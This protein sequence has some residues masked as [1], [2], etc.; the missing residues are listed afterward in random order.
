MI[1]VSTD[2]Y[3]HLEVQFTMYRKVKKKREEEEA[4]DDY[5]MSEQFQNLIALVED[6]LR[7]Q[8]HITREVKRYILIGKVILT[9]FGHTC[10]FITN[11]HIIIY[12]CLIIAYIYYQYLNNSSLR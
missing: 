3:F 6:D 8:Q 10:I 4:K 12:S 11:I 9:H 1:P 7:N 2:P 5:H